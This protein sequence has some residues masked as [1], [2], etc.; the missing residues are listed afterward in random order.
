M[1]GY[2]ISTVKRPFNV[3]SRGLISGKAQEVVR[4]KKA[5]CADKC[6]VKLFKAELGRI[7]GA[8]MPFACHHRAV[9][10]FAKIVSHGDGFTSCPRYP[11]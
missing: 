8:K 7:G 10:S 2:R 4:I 1:V 3:G 5:F 9:A 6:A 11:G